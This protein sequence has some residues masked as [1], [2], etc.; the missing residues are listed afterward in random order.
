MEFQGY[1]FPLGSEQATADV[2][3]GAGHGLLTVEVSLQM[4]CDVMEVI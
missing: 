2:V 4:C 3:G 1:S